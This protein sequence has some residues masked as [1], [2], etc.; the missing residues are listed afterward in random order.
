MICYRLAH[1]DDCEI[2]W[3]F[4]L[5]E[6]PFRAAYFES[7]ASAFRRRQGD[8]GGSPATGRLGESGSC[9]K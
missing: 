5:C 2:P 4:A 3:K 9:M 7:T 6:K 8:V 1:G